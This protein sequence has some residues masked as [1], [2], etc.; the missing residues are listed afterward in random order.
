MQRKRVGFKR[1]A[2]LSSGLL[3]MISMQQ[4][5]AS[6]LSAT[7]QHEVDTTRLPIKAQESHKNVAANPVIAPTPTP[8]EQI[9]LGLNKPVSPLPAAYLLAEPG[10]GSDPTEQETSPLFGTQSEKE[11]MV[12]QKEWVAQVPDP[13]QNRPDPNRDRFIQPAPTPVP[14][15]PEQ[16]QPI[17]PTPRPTPTPESPETPPDQSNITIPVTKIEVIG[18]TILRPAE[19]EPITQPIETKGQATLE[20][21]RQAADAI[22]QLYLNRGY[23]TS[24]AVLVDQTIRDG[25]VQIQVVEGSLEAIKIEGNQ[26]VRESYIRSRILLGAK[27]PLNRD[28]LE[29]QL[30]LLKADPLFTNV[31]ASLRPGTKLGQSVLIVRVT[32]AS[33]WQGFVGVDNFSPPSV[34]SVRFG[35]G[36]GYRNLTGLGDELFASYFR[37]TTGGSS[38]GDFSF[39]MPV[40]AMNGAVQLRFSPSAS[41]ITDSQFS[42]LGIEGSSNLYE[43]NFRQPLLRNPREEFAVSVGFSAQNGQTF[44]FENLGFPFGIGPDANGNS[45]TRVFKFGQDYTRRDVLGAWTFRSLFSVGAGILDATENPDPIPDGRFLSWLGQIQRVQRIGNSNLLIVQADLQLTPDTLL[46]S[47]QFVIGGGQSLRGYRQNFRSGDNGFRVSIEDRIVVLRDA[48]GLPVLQVAPFFD[49]GKVWNTSGNPNPQPSKRFLAGIGAGLLWEPLPRLNIRLDYAYPI[50]Q[51]SDRGN[52][53][54][55]E[56]F[57]FSVNY[58]F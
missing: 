44:L 51:P 20:E 7:N 49:F 22:T 32:E 5:Y 18:S 26:R 43:I 58:Q 28:N 46:P 17:I 14:T 50:T 55:D 11:A 37:S 57:Y 12:R 54:Q 35:G 9:H 47:Q 6:P 45:R 30:R 24:R 27:P 1:G 40:N 25:L 15:P 21:L 3:W 2:S 31:E 33:P 56:A 29:D 38:V 52:D 8:P 23:I 34:G 42:D 4:G 36:I 48:S 19:L 13:S 16:T 53:A 41:R 39:R 10:Q